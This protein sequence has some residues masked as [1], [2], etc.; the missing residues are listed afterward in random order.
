MCL[1]VGLSVCLSVCLS[2]CAVSVRGVFAGAAA[3]LG[4][5]GAG[6]PWV[7]S[8]AGTGL[9]GGLQASLQP[10]SPLTKQTRNFLSAKQAVSFLAGWEGGRSA[11]GA[12]WPRAYA[13]LKP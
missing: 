8:G 13:Y 7:Q 9:E 10:P 2:P 11:L 4:G 6:V 12:S 1:S 3:G 5:A